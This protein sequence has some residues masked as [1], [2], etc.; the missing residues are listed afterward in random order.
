MHHILVTSPP[1]LSSN[2]LQM[3]K[4]EIIFSVLSMNNHIITSLNVRQNTS[5]KYGP[6]K[7]NLWLTNGLIFKMN[8]WILN[9]QMLPIFIQ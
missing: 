9:D 2:F 1:T 7:E 6:K 4:L 8:E 5:L 3:V